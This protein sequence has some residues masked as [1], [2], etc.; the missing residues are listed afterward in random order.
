MYNELLDACK[1]CEMVQCMS[2]PEVRNPYRG[3]SV[4]TLPLFWAE[5]VCG[6]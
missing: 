2:F 5:K 1:R 4:M 6:N 3:V